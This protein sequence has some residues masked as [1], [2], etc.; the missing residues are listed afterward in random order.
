MQHF[1]IRLFYSFQLVLLIYFTSYNIQAQEDKKLISQNNTDTVNLEDNQEALFQDYLDTVFRS[2]SL[3]VDSTLDWDNKKINSGHFDYQKMTDTVRFRVADPLTHEIF[4]PPFQS[5]VNCGFGFRRNLFHFGIDI[6]LHKGDT[7]R[8]AFDGL[9]R[10]TKYDRHG[11]GN[12]VVIRHEKGLETIYGHLS[13][14]LVLPNQ[15]VK[16]GDVIGLGGSTGRSTGSHLHFETRY[17]GEPFDPS[18]FY[19]FENNKLI[20]DTLVITKANFDYLVELSKIKY[21]TIRK[22]DTL[23]KIALRYNTT[24]ASICR[25]NNISTKT[26]LRVG[27]KLRYN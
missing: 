5:H 14:V 13:K 4:Y 21:C 22:G 16:A 12:V 23:G 6:K 3:V 8:A 7:V 2:D 11:Y 26:L 1:V 20:T 9:V 19:D 18:C 10:V 27:R 25:L 24:I 15:V 17:L